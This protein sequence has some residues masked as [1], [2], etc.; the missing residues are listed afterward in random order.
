M[1]VGAVDI[2]TNSTR[3]LV[4]EVEDGKVEEVVRRLAITG[5]GRGVDA[6]GRLADDAQ[7]RVFAVIDRYAAEARGLGAANVLAT[8]TSAVR[9]AANGREFLAA[10]AH[11]TGFQTRLLSG[12]Q[13]AATTLAGVTSDREILTGTLLVDIG[14]GSTE[15][16]L[17]GP[18]GVSFTTSLQ[19]GCVRMTERFLHTDPPAPAEL[20]ACAAHVRSLLPALEPRQAIGVAGTVTTLA[21]LDCKLDTYDPERIHGHALSREAVDGQLARLAAVPLEQRER[22]LHL[23]PARAPVIVGGAVVLTVILDTYGL[24]GIEVS[25]RDIL[26]GTALLAAGAHG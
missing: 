4:A 14:G 21:S 2:G 1:R 5:L 17:G 16:V 19:L 11:R 20:A 15:L 12:E 18:D 25:E 23:E 10:V 3:L 22:I 26:H 9:D 8:A 13:E 6:S 7:A 24:E